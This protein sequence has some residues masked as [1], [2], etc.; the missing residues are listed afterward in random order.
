M[1]EA[2]VGMLTALV[3]VV[4]AMAG[5]AATIA[6]GS[7]GYFNKDRELDIQ[8]VNVSL[9]ILRGEATGDK[10]TLQSRRFALRLLRKYADI[11][12]PEDEFN[13]WAE[14]GNTPFKDMGPN[15]VWGSRSFYMG[16]CREILESRYAKSG[17]ELPKDID[18]E[19]AE[20]AFDMAISEKRNQ[21]TFK[22][23]PR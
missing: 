10:D 18:D 15:S 4:S 22:I 1:S 11:E 13:D 16:A 7:F 5:A 19:V 2:K 14:K 20:C 3:G 12:I 8:M 6:V 23:L 17:K 9:S 21:A